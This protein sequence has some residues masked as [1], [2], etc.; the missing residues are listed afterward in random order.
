MSSTQARKTIW[1]PQHEEILLDLISEKGIFVRRTGSCQMEGNRAKMGSIVE[2][3]NEAV[4]KKNA[5]L[6]AGV[7]LLE[8]E[9]NAKLA[10]YNAT[11]SGRGRGFKPKKP[12]ELKAYKPPRERYDEAAMTSKW[13]QLQTSYHEAASRH[14]VRP[15]QSKGESGGS[16]DTCMDS[17]VE[18][19]S[20][21]FR[22]FRFMHVN[23][24]NMPKLN[25]MLITEQSGEG[26]PFPIGL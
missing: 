7:K 14:K 18:E 19:A 4:K 3:F 10:K 16:G 23:F 1:E 20:K 2:A 6:E 17:K 24:S 5:E 21:D 12:D 15:Y 13:S 25:S 9:Y 22:H 8:I 26:E 11:P